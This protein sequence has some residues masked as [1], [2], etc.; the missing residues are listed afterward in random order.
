[1]QNEHS[2]IRFYRSHVSLETHWLHCAVA[3]SER[4]VSVQ[5]TAGS[6]Y[7][8]CNIAVTPVLPCPL[9]LVL[10]PSVCL[11]TPSCTSAFIKCRHCRLLLIFLKCH[12]FHRIVV[13]LPLL[14][15]HILFLGAS[16][17]FSRVS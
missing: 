9:T 11:Q 4:G 17:S 1:M 13:T 15:N 2:G 8:R 6:C 10:D 7:V 12:S 16:R 14:F 5:W 3:V